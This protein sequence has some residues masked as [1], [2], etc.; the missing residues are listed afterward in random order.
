MSK[1]RV[2]RRID[3]QSVSSDGD[4]GINTEHITKGDDRR[5]RKKCDKE[6]TIAL[7][8]FSVTATNVSVVDHLSNLLESVELCD[9]E[10]DGKCA[11][12]NLYFNLLLLTM[13]LF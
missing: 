8:G 1:D 4:L 13:F 12:A 10:S 2:C 3:M 9:P 5:K 7:N 11:Y 6:A